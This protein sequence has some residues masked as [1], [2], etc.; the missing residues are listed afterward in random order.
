MTPEQ[1]QR[2]RP[3]LESAL[4]LDAASRPAFL[5]GACENLFLRR[6]V[7]SLI[8][9]HEQAGTNVLEPGSAVKLKL[10]EEAEFRL[11]PGRRIGV[12]EIAEEIAVGGMGAVYR[13]IRADGQYQQQV[14]LKIV[15]S[16]LGAES[17]ATRFRNERQ[18]LASLDHPN[19]AKILDGGTTADGLPYLVMEFIDGLPL[20][21]YC[22]QGKLTIDERLKIFRTV[23][24]A[25]HYAHQRLVI[26][27][28][29]K[30]SNILISS[31]G[32]PKLLDFGIAK[33]LDPGLVAENAAAT[34]GG[35]WVMTPEYA[36]PEQLR[37]EA[38]TT[39]TDVYSLGLI[40]YELLAGH[41]A[42]RLANHLPHE[43]AR[44]VLETDPEKPSTAIRRKDEIAEQ[45]EE[46]VPV[47][48]GLI[49]GLRADSPEKLHRRIAGDLDN[50][51][52]KAIRKDPCERYS[53]ADQLSED[54][55][56][57]LEH[58]PILARKSTV[59]YR[60]RQYVLRHKVGVT[61]AALVFLSLLAGIALTLREARIARAN[62]LRA[63]RRFNDVR[64]LANALVFDVHDSIKDLAGATPARKLLV[65]KGLEYLDSLAR[66]SRGDASLQ[67][68]LAAAYMRIGE[69]QGSPFSPNLG[70]S[71]GAKQ[72]YQ[73]ALDIS[74]SLANSDPGS[75]Q[76]AVSI[77]QCYRSLSNVLLVGGDTATALED[78][79]RAVQ[80]SEQAGRA[81]PKD[82][83]LLQELQRDY[84]TEA[85][86]F[87]SSV[88]ASNLGDTSSALPLRRKQL[89]L[90][91]QLA[92]LEPSN[93]EL[94]HTLG[95]SLLH[96]GDQLAL[97]G[98][99]REATEYYVRAQKML[100]QLAIQSPNAAVVHHLHDTY[101]ALEL[102]ELADGD[103]PKAVAAARSALEIAKEQSL[104]DPKNT[105]ISLA[106]AADYVSLA[107]ALSHTHN[108]QEAY[109]AAEKSV[110]IL[111]ELVKHYPK[112]TEFQTMRAIHLSYV[113]DV[114][115]RFS[116]YSSAL[117]YSR[118]AVA[119]LVPIQA[120]DPANSGVRH[121]LATACNK[122]AR[123]LTRLQDLTSATEMY[124]RALELTLS[125][126]TSTHPTEDEVYLVA[127]SYAG[128]GEIEML[129][130]KERS[131]NELDRRR[132][133]KQARTWLGQSM[134][135]W[136]EVKEPGMTS[137][138]GTEYVPISVVKQR[139]G[140]C[141]AALD[142][143]ETRGLPSQ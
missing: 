77:A 44:A 1:W 26:H 84:E 108:R 119:I 13:A 32:V 28:D 127:D 22:D 93:T 87:A 16:E 118:D 94:Q 76:N 139:L 37:G 68:E 6:E 82:L 17:T 39:A 75:L 59:V 47:A 9:S 78:S 64:A 103:V 129:K 7:E 125:K 131:Q 110:G 46:K 56:R 34:L 23:C 51:V 89:D 115:R 41:R 52:M 29:I 102:V 18:I 106:L 54:I 95:S 42:Y 60:C 20:T 58:V 132:H 3:I 66:E 62:E 57:H 92:A 10:D 71:A 79:R 61:A 111:T 85:D 14:A 35:L 74:L 96:M 107:D 49:S 36:S 130:A 120:E 67:S 97:D 104:A 112:N 138:E 69:V 116:D 117:K 24:S 126:G 5:D 136:S 40:L 83:K 101:Y 114:F 8:D 27:R 43:I 134:T 99:R 105:Q 86:I 137:P 143:F 2:V 33:I 73:K 141:Q 63:E 124:K 122:S 81:H 128:L 140:R 72:S 53:S 31:G 4:E 88:V 19:I 30:P 45:D 48:P 133:W 50:I 12:Y 100:K 98:R 109:L 38:I 11:P 121:W 91:E 90:A 113:S 123:I 135:A 15:R 142:R 70:D 80:T 25:V 21:E 65:A 55:R